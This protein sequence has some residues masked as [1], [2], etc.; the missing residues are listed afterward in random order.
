MKVRLVEKDE[1]LAKLIDYKVETE[2]NLTNK[3]RDL[4][5][6]RAARAKA[7]AE[8]LTIQEENQDVGRVEAKQLKD[9]N[10]ELEDENR[11]LQSQKVA[12][13]AYNKDL[14]TMEY[15]G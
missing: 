2:K 11:I 1:T 8:V 5:N 9:R 10:Q 4:N 15:I 13:V 14:G 6:E 12:I 3:E 7:Q